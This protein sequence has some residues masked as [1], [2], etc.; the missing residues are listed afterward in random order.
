MRRVWVLIQANR[1]ALLLQGIT[2]F[3]LLGVV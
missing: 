2:N 3:L 1:Q